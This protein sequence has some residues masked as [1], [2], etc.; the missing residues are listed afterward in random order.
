M[1][2]VV[3]DG[4]AAN[5]GDISWEQMERLGE[6]TVY[7]RT[8]A[9]LVPQRIAEAELVLTN[10]VV[11]SRELIDGAPELKYIGVLATGVNVVDLAAARERGIPVTNIPAYSTQSVAQMTFA[12][13][14]ELCLHV[15]DHSRAVH[16]GR[17]VAS[18]DFCFWDFP[19]IELAGKT[20]GLV[21]FGQIGRAV[22]RIALALGM[23]VVAYTRSPIAFEGVQQVTLAQL[24]EES[25]VISL[26]CP[27]TKSTEGLISRELLSRVKEGCL[28]INTARGPV[29]DEQA[30][31]DALRSGRLAG[32]AMDVISA[33]PMRAENPLL[34]APNC[35]ITPHI[36]WAPKECR[37][38]LMDIAVGNVRAFLADEPVNVVN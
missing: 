28:L 36:A 30:V 38:R 5:P 18:Q 11:L 3:L 35:V 15:G 16:E 20:M 34:G 8:P 14:L 19:L 37:Q 12:L 33:E 21:G 6:L 17:W 23:R 2:I 7:E 26:H 27:L 4:F 25:D 13:L 22:A 1:K 31:A 9:A 32:A 10:K 29:V 24:V